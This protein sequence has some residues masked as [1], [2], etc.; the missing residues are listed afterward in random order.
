MALAPASA[1]PK[2]KDESPAKVKQEEDAPPPPGL[3]EEDPSREEDKLK[4]TP[5]VRYIGKK[6]SRTK[7][8]NGS[9]LELRL[10]GAF[11]YNILSVLTRHEWVAARLEKANIFFFFA[12]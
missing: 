2:V 6:L 5:L 10:E 7:R 9:A 1:T 11:S 3:D 12:I 4:R 8:R